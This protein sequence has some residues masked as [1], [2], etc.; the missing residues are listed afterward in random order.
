MVVAVAVTVWLG[1]SG[2]LLA[3][4]RPLR[5]FFGIYEGQSISVTE[6]GLQTR[7]L[8]VTIRPAKRGF[9]LSWTTVIHTESDEHSRKSYS[10]DFVLTPDSHV[11]ASAMR[12]D[13]FG[14][15]VPLDPMKGDPFVWARIT[16]NTLSVYALIIAPDGGYD[17]QTYDRTLIDDGL[18]LEFYRIREGQIGT[19][20]TG[21]LKRVG[22]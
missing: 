7:D 20:V 4:H 8:G 21:F 12:R 2:A 10:I 18:R 9:S 22:N 14:H 1:S 11:F 19:M 16:G 5:D 13:M 17:L 3:D 15:R 6:Y